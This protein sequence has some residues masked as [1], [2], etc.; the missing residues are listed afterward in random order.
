MVN[1]TKIIRLG[2]SSLV[3]ATTTFHVRSFGACCFQLNRFHVMG[4]AFVTFRQRYHSVTHR[5]LMSKQINRL[6][7][8]SRT[9]E[10]SSIGTNTYSFL[11]KAMFKLYCCLLSVN[12]P[13]DRPSCPFQVY[14]T[15]PYQRRHPSSTKKHR[16]TPR[17]SFVG[18]S[19][20]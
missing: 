18:S 5:R 11:T 20:F 4:S 2:E 10:T 19:R 14:Y 3:D 15:I 17:T 7:K 13:M 8:G 12:T 6:L 16:E 1:A 9:V